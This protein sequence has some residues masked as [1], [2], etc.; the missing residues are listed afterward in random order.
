MLVEHRHLQVTLA[1][2]EFLR[3]AQTR[4]VHKQ[5]HMP[6]MLMIIKRPLNSG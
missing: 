2:I 5:N 3:K 6:S 1:F 4:L